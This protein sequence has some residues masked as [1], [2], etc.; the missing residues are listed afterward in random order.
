MVKV[1]QEFA[2]NTHPVKYAFSIGVPILVWRIQPALFWRIF[3]FHYLLAANKAM[4]K[5]DQE[6]AYNTHP[7]KYAI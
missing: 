6:F 2:Y 7:V 3:V 4:V 1:D 5:V